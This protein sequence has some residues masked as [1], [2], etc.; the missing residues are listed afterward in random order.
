MLFPCLM[1]QNFK[2]NPIFSHLVLTNL[3]FKNQ[4]VTSLD[5]YLIDDSEVHRVSLKNLGMQMGIHG[6]GGRHNPHYGSG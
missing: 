6:S 4:G 3:V 2:T 1:C 5:A